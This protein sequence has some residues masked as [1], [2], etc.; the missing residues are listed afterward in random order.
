MLQIYHGISAQ[1]RR[2]GTSFASASDRFHSNSLCKAWRH[3]HS[4]SPLNPFCLNQVLKIGF[5]RSVARFSP[6]AAALLAT[7]AALLYIELATHAR[8]GTHFLL[9]P[10]SNGNPKPPPDRPHQSRRINARS[11]HMLR[12]CPGLARH[13]TSFHGMYSRSCIPWR[14]NAA[15]QPLRNATTTTP[16]EQTRKHCWFCTGTM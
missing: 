4:C 11:H 16:C 13:P 15:V 1:R 5:P 2:Q 12:R 6:T 10:P 3:Q 7:A 9:P 8:G 14:A